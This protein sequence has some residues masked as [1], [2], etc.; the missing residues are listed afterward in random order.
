MNRYH[1]VGKRF[2]SNLL[3]GLVFLPLGF[4]EMGLFTLSLPK[5]ILITWLI[6]TYPLNWLYS[7]LMH[8]FYGQTLGKMACGIK[9][10]DVSEKTIGIRQAFL[11][12]IFIIV[13]NTIF[14]AYAV[15]F[16]LNDI[17]RD[18]SEFER[19][20]IYFMIAIY[21]WLIAEI[22]TCLTNWKRRAMHD[23]IAGTV[24]VRLDMLK[25]KEEPDH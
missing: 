5:Y 19:I 4:I 14:V 9:V 24:V 7:V 21:A 25:S 10:L 20:N 18:G 16:V 17:P 13:V 23:F 22:I 8:A 12:D 1:T 3:D 6:V 15:Y 11:R 2:W